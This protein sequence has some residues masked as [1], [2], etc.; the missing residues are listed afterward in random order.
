MQ[1]E[2]V[3]AKHVPIIFDA[4]NVLV[5]ATLGNPDRSINDFRM[6]IDTNTNDMPP[7]SLYVFGVGEGDPTAAEVG[8]WRPHRDAYQAGIEAFEELYKS[9]DDIAI[10][11]EAANIAVNDSVACLYR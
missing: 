4:A 9:G 10:A 7:T 11:Y 1:P 3:A 2:L 6:Y 8:S 5:K